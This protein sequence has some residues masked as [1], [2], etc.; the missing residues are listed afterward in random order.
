MDKKQQFEKEFGELKA[1]LVKENFVITDENLRA[2]IG[3]KIKGFPLLMVGPTGCGKTHLLSL[4]SEYYKGNYEYKSLNGSV[5][6]RDLVQERLLAKDGTFAEKDMVLARWLRKAQVGFSMLH[7]DEVNAARPETLLALHPIMD[8]KGELEL[9][10]SGEI[11]KVNDNAMLAMSANEGDEY[12]GINAMNAAFQN[13]YVKI[14]LPYIQGKKLMQLLKNKTGVTEDVA[15]AV[16][17]T[18]EKYMHSR[19]PEQPV[20][21]IRV[22]ERW[23]EMSELI[24]VRDAGIMCFASLVAENEDALAEIVHGDFFVNLPKN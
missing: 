11:L 6:I 3:A 19:K 1:F 16:Q 24:G 18:W 14:H 15:T 21:S 12:V 17:N 2:V 22:L 4:I 8:I 9:P 5:T 13:R 20:I 23:C 7:L 10:Y